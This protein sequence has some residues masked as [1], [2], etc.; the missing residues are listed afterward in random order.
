MN[1]FTVILPVG[2]N[3]REIY[4]SGQGNSISQNSVYNGIDVY[5][6]ENHIHN[7]T[8]DMGLGSGI[9][10]QGS[11]NKIAYNDV[12][13][14]SL[15]GIY[16]GNSQNLIDGNQVMTS[17]QEALYIAGTYGTTVTERNILK[18]SCVVM[19][20]DLSRTKEN[21]KIIENCNYQGLFHTS[22]LEGEIWNLGYYVYLYNS[23]WITIDSLV[24][25]NINKD[26]AFYII[27]SNNISINSVRVTSIDKGEYKGLNVDSSEH[28]S[29]SNSQFENL[30]KGIYSFNSE[31]LD[32][33]DN[34]FTN[35]DAGIVDVGSGDVIIELNSFRNSA[36]GIGL[37]N[38]VFFTIENNGLR[39][40][41]IKEMFGSG[42]GIYV[43]SSIHGSVINNEIS[44]FDIAGIVYETVSYLKTE[45]NKIY[46]NGVG[47]DLYTISSRVYLKIYNND[48]Y[49]NQQ[50]GIYSDSP[51]DARFNWWGDPSGPYQRCESQERCEG[52]VNTEGKGNPVNSNVDAS[53]PLY[54]STQGTVVNSIQAIAYEYKL[55]IILILVIGAVAIVAW[56]RGWFE[57]WVDGTFA[58]V[59]TY[60]MASTVLEKPVVPKRSTVKKMETKTITIQCTNCSEKIKV[61]KKGS[62]QKITCSNC[63]TSGEINL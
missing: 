56:K 20:S 5:G 52:N 10:I 57:N 25:E 40:D 15:Y 47:I 53:E 62:L 33:R 21:K 44:G 28:I 58:P 6:D 3:N 8:V 36:V 60:P 35:C 11:Y 34:V 43:S 38:S 24:Y 37:T 4:V 46:D 19:Y 29:V 42:I 22:D 9:I 41:R 55:P 39:N 31:F 13:N 14:A 45:N 1:S 2:N 18:G 27:E 32:F 49:D 63:G 26:S 48:I 23:S 16:V 61:E 7:N 17:S 51:V 50:Y 54:G 59:N 30:D 12:K